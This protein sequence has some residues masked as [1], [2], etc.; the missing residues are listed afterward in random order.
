MVA[1]S[2]SSMFLE[3]SA[4]W[5]INRNTAILIRLLKNPRMWGDRSL[6]NISNKQ[7]NYMA[8]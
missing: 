2:L 5:Q 8:T 4:K 7:H 3:K 6:T 1:M